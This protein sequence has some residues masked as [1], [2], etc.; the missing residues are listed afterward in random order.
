MQIN[1]ILQPS[2]IASDPGVSQPKS[3]PRQIGAQDSVQIS[4]TWPRISQPIH[5]S[6][7]EVAGSL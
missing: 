5:R 7:A 3:N 4:R 1:N 2:S 6:S